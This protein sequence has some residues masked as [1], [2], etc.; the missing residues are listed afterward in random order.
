[1]GQFKYLFE[2]RDN[3]L[4]SV[5]FTQKNILGNIFSM[6][7]QPEKCLRTTLRS[8]AGRT[9]FFFE[10]K[11]EDYEVFVNAFMK[12]VKKML[13]LIGLIWALLHLKFSPLLKF[14][15]RSLHKTSFCFIFAD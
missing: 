12:K 1:M 4:L 15:F 9:I 3:E 7:Y 13:I 5:H 11:I 14:F 2:M 10:I 6:F 8:L